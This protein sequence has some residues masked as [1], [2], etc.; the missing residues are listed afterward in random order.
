MGKSTAEMMDPSTFLDAG[1]DFNQTG[2][3]W[4]MTAG[5]TYPRLAWETL[6]NTP[7][8]DLNLH[9]S[10]TGIGEPTGRYLGRAVHRG[11]SGPAHHPPFTLVGGAI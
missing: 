1:W 10:P 7:P 6:P 11:G 9:R 5:Q 8:S 4:K 3:T 2:G